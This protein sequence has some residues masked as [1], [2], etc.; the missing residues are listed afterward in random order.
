VAL[1]LRRDRFRRTCLRSPALR[2]G[3]SHRGG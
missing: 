3:E 2:H 1:L